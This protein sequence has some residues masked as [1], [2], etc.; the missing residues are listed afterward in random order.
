MMDITKQF[1][2]G[3]FPQNPDLEYYGSLSAS[4]LT[5]AVKDAFSSSDML[6]V[7]AL[8][9]GMLLISAVFKAISEGVGKGAE[10]P[11]D[12]ASGAVCCAALFTVLSTAYKATEAA[13]AAMLSYMGVITVSM[14]SIDL[15]SGH[16]AFTEAAGA[17]FAFSSVIQLVN[18]NLLMPLTGVC[19]AAS[20]VSCVSPSTGLDGAALGIKKAVVFGLSGMAGLF[21]AFIGCKSIVARGAETLAVR[22]VKFAAQSFVPVIGAAFSESLTAYTAALS[23]VRRLCG[24]GAIFALLFVILPP[25]VTLLTSKAT[26]YLSSLLSGTLGLEKQ[27]KM[28]LHTMEALDILLA[29]LLSSFGVFVIT[30]ALFAAV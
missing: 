18:S 27:S 16:G 10:L 21:S 15:A 17:V 19:F 7:L 30:S 29:V 25:L 6:G 11:L 5:D 8:M 20:V 14:Y 4:D 22:G 24:V 9:C 2:E 1:I 26:L 13:L 28:L 12:I 23:S 3:Y